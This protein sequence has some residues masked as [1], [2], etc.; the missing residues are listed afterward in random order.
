M[1]R[2]A[3]AGTISERLRTHLIKPFYAL[4]SRRAIRISRRLLQFALY[5]A[6]F[7]VLAFFALARTEQG[8]KILHSGTEYLINR[9]LAGHLEIGRLSGSVPGRLTAQQV[10]VQAPDGKTIAR[11]DSVI[12]HPTWRSLISR[13][14]STG[15]VTLV[16][17]RLTLQRDE[18]GVWNITELFQAVTDT[19]RSN[20]NTWSFRSSL[21]DIVEG[22][23]RTQSAFPSSSEALFD[24]GNASMENIDARLEIDITPETKII[25]ALDFQARLIDPDMEITRLRGQLTAQESNIALNDFNLR[26]TESDLYLNGSISASDTLSGHV[27]SPVLDIRLDRS[28]IHSEELGRVFPA[29]PSIETVT[30]SANVRGPF[31]ALVIDHIT[32]EKNASTLAIEGSLLG[33]PDSLDYELAIREGR[34]HWQDIHPIQRTIAIPSFEYLGR[35]AFTGYVK[36]VAHFR[37]GE[38]APRWQGTHEFA[39]ES[40]AGNIKG[41]TRITFNE[42]TFSVDGAMDMTGVDAGRIFR[43]PNLAGEL[44]GR[45]ALHGEGPSLPELI[46]EAELALTRSHTASR[47]F[48]TLHVAVAG[49]RHAFR[50]NFH[51]AEGSGSLNTSFQ[52]DLT[53]TPLQYRMEGTTTGLNI[54]NILRNDSLSSSLNTRFEVEG[55]GMSWANF[56]GDMEVAFGPSVMSMGTSQR[57]IPAHRSSL[58]I[59]QDNTGSSEGPQVMLYGDM[60]A[61]NITG[62]I[63]LEPVIQLARHWGEAIARS[64]AHETS[65]PYRTVA[66]KIEPVGPGRRAGSRMVT[67]LQ[68]RQLDIRL[69]VLRSDI[70]AALFP[71][72]PL[73]HTDLRAEGR[74]RLAPDRFDLDMRVEADSLSTGEVRAYEVS[75]DMSAESDDADAIARTLRSTLSV[76]ISD[77]SVKG[78]HFERASLKSGFR[79]RALDFTAQANTPGTVTPL[80]LRARMDILNDRNRLFIEDLQIAARNQI[81]T[82]TDSRIVDFYKDAIHIPDIRITRQDNLVP[83]SQGYLHITGTLSPAPQDTLLIRAEDIRMQHAGNL[84]SLRNR[85]DGQL[86][87]KLAFTGWGRR[88]ELTG[89]VFVDSLTFRNRPLGYLALDSRYIP[90]SPDVALQARLTPSTAGDADPLPDRNDLTLNGTFRLPGPQN[91]SETRDPGALDLNLRIQRADAFFF[92]HLFSEA[93]ADVTGYVD[94]SGHIGGNFSKPAFNADL[95]LRGVRFHIPEF[96]LAY[97]A[98]GPLVVDR[99][100]I[101]LANLRLSDTRNGTAVVGGSIL[102][103]DYRFFSFSLEGALDRL[104]VMNV[105]NSRELPFYGRI[106]AS[107]DVM[108]RGP[109]SNALL[110]SSELR[111]TAGSEIYIPVAETDEN[112]D[113]GFIVFADSTGH[114]PSDSARITRR[115]NLLTE[116][117]AGERP[118]VDGLDIDVNILS[119][120]GTTVH[121]VIDPLLGDVINAR[122]NGRVQLGRSEGEFFTF[123]DFTITSG[124]YLFTATEVFSRRFL[125]DSGTISWDGDPLNARMVIAA[126]YRTRASL[127]GLGLGTQQRQL[128]PLVIELG[129]NG[130]VATPIVDLRLS[131]DREK[132]GYIGYEGLEALLNQPERAAQYATSVLLTNSFLL[133]EQQPLTQGSSSGILIFHSLSQLVTGQLNR[134]INDALPGVEFNVN[135]HGENAQDLGVAVA[136][137]LQLLDE[138]LI[139]RGHGIYHNDATGQQQNGLG[140][141]V[142]EVRLGPHVSMDVFY[143]R[144][145]GILLSTESVND[146]NTTGAGLSYKTGFSTWRRLFSRLFGQGG[147]IQDDNEAPEDIAVETADGE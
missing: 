64:A 110:E 129:V 1:Q 23:I 46:G 115:R 6:L 114:T 123:G 33:L 119:P 116:R 88:P 70:L 140:E 51:A 19:S 103:N 137:A 48:D 92:E 5:A 122:G 26:T 141:V 18:S 34:I 82:A 83:G 67:G 15:H 45:I 59:R 10:V 131:V 117:P 66:A 144:E 113:T 135:V 60:A 35:I 29:L 37:K 94:G 74:L 41:D 138:R 71:G 65:K 86:G 56:Q 49:T 80:R 102:F 89:H 127:E 120:E 31:E 50:G 79:N 57:I 139:I 28:T 55:S 78:R 108:L 30:T 147:A 106:W 133:A 146:T 104:N 47:Q 134:Y 2:V 143:R 121:L 39:V 75:G 72:L 40:N 98:T 27:S 87:G 58:S 130:R 105:R 61:L 85:I 93:I 21:V 142:V 84:I 8:R 90:G 118:F 52:A 53:A 13:T 16:R 68:A 128:I 136:V 91:A 44:T 24:W 132:R 62:D 99:Q 11:I 9:S 12:L 22:S 32:L 145:D 77:M 7:G 3:Y 43:K 14:I 81:W 125:I 109:I 4:S 73:V 38:T 63:A 54:G 36:G 20:A 124:D 107:G 17:P 126:S 95:A 42:G 111:T 76:T 112:T 100:G 69:Q 25:E 101:H 97:E 96:Q